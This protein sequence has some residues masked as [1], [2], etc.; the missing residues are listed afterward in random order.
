MSD[1]KLQLTEDTLRNR[2]PVFP[3]FR[4]RAGEYESFYLSSSENGPSRAPAD[5][6]EDAVHGTTSPDIRRVSSPFS[7]LLCLYGAEGEE[8]TFSSQG[9]RHVKRSLP[10]QGHYHTHD[11]I[12]ILY[13]AKGSFRQILLGE[14]RTF[15]AGEFA[16]TDRNLEHADVLT[17]DCD[18]IVLFLS[19]QDS[20]LD[21]LLSS[22]DHQDELQR[23]FFHALRRQRKEQ[24]YLHLQPAAP[25]ATFDSSPYV[26][27]NCPGQLSRIL[28]TLI[29]E[30]YFPAEGSA[31][32]IRGSLIRLL[33]LL[34][35][36]YSMKLHSSDQ[37]SR[38]KALL[39]ELERYIRLHFATVTSRELETA[40]HY[41]RNYYNLLLQKYLGVSFQEYLQDIRMKHAAG[42]LRST[43][44]PVKDIALAAGY[45]NSSHFYHLFQRHFGMSPADF[46][47][48]HPSD[49]PD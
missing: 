37:E 6:A 20:Y 41:H 5:M 1:W 10:W 13:V 4:E 43:R 32:I 27:P 14:C 12:E 2:W 48:S 40:F 22:Y 38:E 7:T 3:S 24:S 16:V 45:H 18:A 17:G 28:E 36:R 25:I 21:Q 44:L 31:E 8:Y 42:L 30:D 46:R 19:L 34:C 39:Y 47:A 23:F 29:E 35:R 26:P 11:Y 15:S 49:G 33:S 9:M